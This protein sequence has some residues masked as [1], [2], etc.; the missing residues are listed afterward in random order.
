MMLPSEPNSAPLGPFILSLFIAAGVGGVLF[1][2]GIVAIFMGIS[3]V[4]EFVGWTA[5]LLGLSQGGSFFPV[6]LFWAAVSFAV[7]FAS[8]LLLRASK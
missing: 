6:A 2:G 8:Q 3:P 5:K 1:L 4:I 7:S